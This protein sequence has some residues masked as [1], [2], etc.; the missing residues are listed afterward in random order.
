MNLWSRW[1]R[2]RPEA[3]TLPYDLCPRCE[4]EHGDIRGGTNAMTRRFVEAAAA[5]APPTWRFRCLRCR[6]V[7][8]TIGGSA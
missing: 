8:E 6:R 7:S 2:R 1:N 3:R 4:A 5:I